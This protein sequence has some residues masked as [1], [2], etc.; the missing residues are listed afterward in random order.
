MSEISKRILNAINNSELSYGELS[1]LTNIPK[2][3]LQRYATGET[4]KIP[5]NRIEAI[6]K[7][8][9]TTAAYLMGWDK[10]NASPSGVRIPVLGHVAAG[11][12]IEAI[13]DIIDYEEIP[14]AMAKNGEYFGL[15]IRGNSMEPRILEGDVVIVRKQ[16]DVESGEIAVVLVNGDEATCKRVVKS[17][18][19]ITLIALNVAAYP[20]HF[21]TAQEVASLP[22][23]IVG[24]VVELRGKV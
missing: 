18:A 13:E 17:D 10:N 11:I 21:Y 5:I 20:P 7:A 2:S 9:G 14:Q 1:K 15:R 3:A 6:A 24:K 4:E 19:G 23:T 16:P 22:V 8:T 12:P